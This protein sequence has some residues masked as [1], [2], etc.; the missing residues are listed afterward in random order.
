M[1]IE[2]AGFRSSFQ[3]PLRRT[4][5]LPVMSVQLIRVLSCRAGFYNDHSKYNEWQAKH[6]I[7]DKV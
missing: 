4:L 6:L 7:L 3:R 1:M 5:V 2:L